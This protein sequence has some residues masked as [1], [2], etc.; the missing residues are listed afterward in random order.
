MGYGNIRYRCDMESSDCYKQTQEAITW[1]AGGI[2]LQGVDDANGPGHECGLNM[3]YRE[4]IK[5][6][7]EI[8]GVLLMWNGKQI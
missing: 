1:L 8:E 3:V 6:V 5:E 7:E 4:L 2:I